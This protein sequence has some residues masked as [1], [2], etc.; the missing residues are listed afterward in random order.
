MQIK[1]FYLVVLIFFVISCENNNEIKINKDNISKEK[2]V[3]K[4]VKVDRKPFMEINGESFYLDDI[5]NFAN[6]MLSEVDVSTLN[7]PKIKEKIL[8][9]FIKNQVLRQ[10]AEKNNIKVDDKK[11]E[12]I[13]NNF[14]TMTQEDNK[15]I[16]SFQNIVNSK[17]F[18]KNL[19]TQMMIQKL[20]ET[21]LTDEIQISKEEL[22]NYYNEVIKNYP[23][24]K[25]YHVYHIVTQDKKTAYEARK[26]LRKRNAFAKVAKKYSIGPAKDEGGDLGYIDLKE[27]P[28]VFKN[29][30]KLKIRKISNVIKSDYGYHIFQLK[31]VKYVKKPTFEEIS[32][33]LYADLYSKKQD[34]L[35]TNYIKELIDN[36]KIR[37]YGNFIISSVNTDNASGNN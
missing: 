36:A 2:S 35:I 26:M 28:D 34:N 15:S 33:R 20:I 12:K 30:K 19:K 1:L 22:E 32:G 18:K 29:V 27:Y 24:K 25:L 13:L 4:E 14:K 3:K 17:Q 5:L 6:F 9:D 21:K 7:N 10:E 31:G 8:N 37:V 11:L 16:A 23:R